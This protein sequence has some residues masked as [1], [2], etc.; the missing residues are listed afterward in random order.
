[1]LHRIQVGH[2]NFLKYSYLKGKLFLHLKGGEEASMGEE[3]DK[4]S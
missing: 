2:V 3:S 1:M 4:E